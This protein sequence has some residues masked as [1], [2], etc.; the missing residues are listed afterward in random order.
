MKWKCTVC[1]YIHEGNEPPDECPMCGLGAE[2][3]EP[4]AEEKTDKKFK[5]D[6]SERFVIIGGG[7]AAYECALAIRERNKKCSIVMLS[8]EEVPPYYRPSLSKMIAEGLDIEN[9]VL[10]KESFYDEVDITLWTG[11]TV[12]KIDISNKTVILDNEGIIDYDKLCICTGARAFNPIKA[13]EN[14]IPMQT[15]RT[16]SDAQNLISLAKEKKNAL[17]I[18]GGIL[19]IEAAESLNKLGVNVMV[20]EL[21]DRILSAQPDEEKSASEKARLELMGIKILTNISSTE[22]TSNGVLL[23]NGSVIEADFALVSAGIRSN[24]SI[25][26][27]AGLEVNR[28]IIVDEKMKTSADDVYAAGDCAELNGKVGGLWTVA[29]EQGEIAGSAMTG[30]I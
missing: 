16:F 9:I 26:E 15:L 17:I 10:E 24:I 7:A 21:S 27:E 19:G 13:G 23:K 22:T 12:T 20:A 3:F 25:A 28:G 14:G 4:L 30:E 1:G 2:L 11:V 8:S 29:T 18:G 5:K 6:T